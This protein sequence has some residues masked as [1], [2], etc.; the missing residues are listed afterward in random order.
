MS[1]RKFLLSETGSGAIFTQSKFEEFEN[2]F[3]KI[4]D[5]RDIKYFLGFHNDENMIDYIKDK[6][7][8]HFKLPKLLDSRVDLTDLR[9]P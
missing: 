2:E 6:I 4:F 1:F 5:Y 8:L 7:T 9:N 3:A